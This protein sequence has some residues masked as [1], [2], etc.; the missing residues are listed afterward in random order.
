MER[1]PHHTSAA[2]DG[3]CGMSGMRPHRDGGPPQAQRDRDLIISPTTLPTPPP[4][5]SLSH[6]TPSPNPGIHTI[7]PHFNLRPPPPDP[8]TYRPTDPYTSYWGGM[9]P[10]QRHLH[11]HRAKKKHAPSGRTP[12]TRGTVDTSCLINVDNWATDSDAVPNLKK[13]VTKGR[14]VG[15]VTQNELQQGTCSV[16]TQHPKRTPHPLMSPTNS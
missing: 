7:P 6:P 3:V 2:Q 4:S 12:R 11:P 14:V 5:H 9:Q 1:T 13:Q 15:G 10:Q 16:R 8:P